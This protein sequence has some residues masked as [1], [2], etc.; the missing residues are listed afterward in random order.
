[1]LIFRIFPMI[2]FILSQNAASMGISVRFNLLATQ[3][4]RLAENH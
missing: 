3:Q 4:E 1:M 2:V